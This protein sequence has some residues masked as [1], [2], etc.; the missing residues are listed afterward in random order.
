M[1]RKGHGCCQKGGQDR[2]IQLEPYVRRENLI[3]GR[4]MESDL[5]HCQKKKEYF[6]IINIMSCSGK[7]EYLF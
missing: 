5:D 7:L 4:L 3:F 1:V 6:I 2:D